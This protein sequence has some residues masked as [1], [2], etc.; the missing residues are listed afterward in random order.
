M[1]LEDFKQYLFKPEQEYII[2]RTVEIQG[3]KA[4]L[5]ALTQSGET[6]TLWLLYAYGEKGNP[7]LK[8]EYSTN[9]ERLRQLVGESV[10]HINPVIEKVV[11]NEG[12]YQSKS[13]I[14]SFFTEGAID[15]CFMLWHFMDRGVDLDGFKTE[16]IEHLQIEEVILDGLYDFK[17]PVKYMSLTVRDCPYRVL[18][19]EPVVLSCGQPASVNGPYFF[20]DKEGGGPITY[21][22]NGLSHYDVWKAAGKRFADEEIKKRFTDKQLKALKKDYYDQLAQ[23]CPQGMDLAV[24]E[25]ETDDNTQLDFYTREYLEARPEAPQGSAILWHLKPDREQG[26]HGLKNRACIIKTVEK[27]FQGDIEAEVF[28]QWRKIPGETVELALE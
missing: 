1:K 8:A 5:L 25:Y 4:G 14:G 24:I 17:E 19:E 15:S 21:Y 7:G 23:T 6:M 16:E 11:I 20:M 9:R 27:D 28:N 12:E 26:P 2:N 13:S 3:K 10:H 18:M 22:V